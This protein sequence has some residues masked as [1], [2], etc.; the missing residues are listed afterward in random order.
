MRTKCGTPYTTAPE[1][2]RECY[3]ER[4]DVWSIGVV[5]YIMLSGRRP[6]ETLE[7]AGGLREAGK[8]L[9]IFRNISIAI[10]FPYCICL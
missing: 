8:N 4:C 6:F 1:V 5:L 9:I 2:F 3:D 7:V 10:M